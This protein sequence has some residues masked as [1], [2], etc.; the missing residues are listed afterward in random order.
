MTNAPVFLSS[1]YKFPP[2]VAKCLEDEKASLANSGA[3]L[4]PGGHQETPPRGKVRDGVSS[5][6]ADIDTLV[7]I[8]G[9][10]I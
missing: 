6:G 9:C 10:S 7:R 8:C 2:C 5:R 1:E 3:F 4:P